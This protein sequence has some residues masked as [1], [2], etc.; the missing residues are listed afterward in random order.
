MTFSVEE[1]AKALSILE[2]AKKVRRLP[3]TIHNWINKGVGVNGRRVKL[4]AVR[5][6]AR[7]VVMPG[8]LEQFIRD[9]NPETQPVPESPKIAHARAMRE[10]EAARRNL[11]GA[12]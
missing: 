5:I 10:R 2:A 6:G 8:D 1:L 9:T 3:L 4:R 12:K 11:G 7:W